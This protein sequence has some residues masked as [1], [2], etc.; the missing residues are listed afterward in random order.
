MLNQNA[1]D[2]LVD[3]IKSTELLTPQDSKDMSYI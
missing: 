3:D 1:L 2:S